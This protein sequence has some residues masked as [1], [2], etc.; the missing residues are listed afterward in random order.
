M[1]RNVINALKLYGDPRLRIILLLG[2][3]SGL[4]FALT[5]TTLTAW[6]NDVGIEKKEISLFAAVGIAYSFNYL[7]APLVDHIK[8]PFLH[9]MGRRRSWMFFSQIALMGAIMGMAT[10][11]PAQLP[12]FTA[13]FAVCVAFASATQDIVID[14]YRTEILDKRQYGEGAAVGVFG[15]RM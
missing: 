1:L 5:F 3:S 8:L 7:W 10:F 15:Y 2:F 11:N 9:T 4:P 13:F 6:L 12:L 14:A